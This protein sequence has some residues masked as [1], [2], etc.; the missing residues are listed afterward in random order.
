MNYLKIY[1]RLIESSI[2]LS[3]P[4]II[5][6]FISLVSIPIHLNI[7]GAENYG[8]YIIFHF[9]LI[10]TQ[11]LNFGIGKSIVIS[12]NNF[13]KMNKEISYEGIKYTFYL[14]IIFT[15]SFFIF[16][17]LNINVAASFLKIINIE[18]IYLLIGTIVSIWYLTLEGIFQG[19]EK[20]KFLSFFNFI[21]YSLSLSFPSLLLLKYSFLDNS[22]LILIAL[23]IK[24]IGVFVMLI[25]V[26]S[27]NYLKK[28]NKKT[29]YENLRKNSKWISLNIILIQFYDVID[30]F[31]IKY[32]IGP[33]ALATY[34]IPQQLTGKLSILS[35]GISAFLLP[36]LSKINTS[37]NNLN[38]T[39]DVFLRY[40]PIFIFIIYP[41]FEIF[42]SF[43]LN[44]QF[45]EN[46]L[47]LTK[48][49]SISA[50]FSCASHILV[51][52]FEAKKKLKI[53]LKIEFLILP[54]FL[55][56]LIYFIITNQ[57]LVII[58]MI[59]LI[60]EFLLLM[61]R[62]YLMQ[63]IHHN[64]VKY[65]LFNL[66]YFFMIFLSFNN[67]YLFYFAILFLVVINLK[68]KSD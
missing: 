7:A 9:I 50:I 55:S 67:I 60:K 31:F 59:I 56:I 57:S 48:I 23:I 22:K 5:S 40:I 2:I 52:N 26:C 21:F 15:V 49:F 35:K 42:L 61:I 44:S 18:I 11:I 37:I 41:F 28:S 27:Y 6:I 19:N 39:L 8:N 34:S 46:I 17:N 14:T 24:S 4:G 36:N 51:T 65:L 47:I 45:N 43:W 12:I 33:I 68:L 16:S 63:N 66:I 32:F 53:N 54:V 3:L 30:K 29:L 13:P 64:F 58:S 38:F 25:L 62:L 1:K 20:F 10:L